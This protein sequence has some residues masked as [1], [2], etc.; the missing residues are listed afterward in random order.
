MDQTDSACCSNLLH[1]GALTSRPSPPV[2]GSSFLL[3][4]VSPNPGVPAAIAEQARNLAMTLPLWD[5]IV[6][7]GLEV[8]SVAAGAAIVVKVLSS[9]AHKAEAVRNV[10]NVGWQGH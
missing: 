5:V 3:P 4:D 8:A 7:A 9:L 2:A 1:P 6:R 10:C